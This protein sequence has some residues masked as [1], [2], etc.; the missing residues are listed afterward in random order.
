MLRVCVCLLL[1]AC[2]KSS[3]PAPAPAPG[4][5]SA[6]VAPAAVDAAVVAIADAAAV[7][8]TTVDAAPIACTAPA[9]G[10]A[11]KEAE[12]HVKAGRYDAAIALLDSE[13]CYLEMDQPDALKLQIAWRLSDLAFAYY[14]AGKFASCYSIAAGQT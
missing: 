8:A 7:D 11:R 4:S 14:K 2:D 1:V 13:S 6:V 10:Q 3:K 9:I 12:A 5:A